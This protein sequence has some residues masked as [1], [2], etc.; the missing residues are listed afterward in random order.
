MSKEHSTYPDLR[1]Q[2]SAGARQV[3]AGLDGLTHATVDGFPVRA[4]EHGASTEKGQWVVLGT[5][6]VD[7]NV[8]Q[9]VLADLLGEVD[10][11]AQEV[12]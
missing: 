12:G 5:S 7:R 10:V 6:I 11:D 4:A 3:L 8:P 9:H 1:L 2:L